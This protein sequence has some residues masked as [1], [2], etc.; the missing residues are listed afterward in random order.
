MSGTRGRL[1]RGYV[2]RPD[3]AR[4]AFQVSGSRDAP[5]LLLLQGQ[6][7][8]HRWWDRLRGDFDADWFTVTFDYRGTGASTASTSDDH[9]WST[10]GF[11]ADAA[12]VLTAVGYN[13]A[14]VYAT[15]MGGRVAQELAIGHADRVSSLVLACTSPGRSLGVERSAELRRALADPDPVRRRQ[16]LIDAF[17]TPAYVNSCGGPQHVPTDLFGDLSMTS[18]AR[19]QHLRVSEAHD[20]GDRLHHITA[21]TTVLHGTDDTMA[22]AANAQHL[23]DAIPDATVHLLAG[24]RH[25]FFDEMREI[26]T[27]L[28]REALSRGGR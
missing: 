28:V 23:Q 17:Y 16:T 19:R 27:P 11:A 25:G 8:S 9:E 24:G 18:A 10:A 3:G 20:A 1:V 15:S 14:D 21:P 7:N 22:P 4:L 2:G 6:A 26:V 13:C 5:A 12:A